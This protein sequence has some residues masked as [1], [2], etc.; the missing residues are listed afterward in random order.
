ME[1][2]EEI[3]AEFEQS[4]LKICEESKNLRRIMRKV[5]NNVSKKL[6]GDCK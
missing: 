4:I 1:S 6:I 2:A 5:K 3:L